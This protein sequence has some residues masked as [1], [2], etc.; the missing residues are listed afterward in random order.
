MT[1]KQIG[2]LTA[3]GSIADTDVFAKDTAGGVT[4]KE[5]FSVFKSTLKT[6][7]DSLT[8][9]F[10]NKRVTR[11]AVTVTQS[12]TPTINTDNADVAHITGLAQAITSMTTGLSG[13][14]VEGDTLRVDITDDGTARAISWGASF[15]ASG[16]VALPTTTVSGV[17][18]DVG[19]L[20]N[21]VSNKWRIV[22]TA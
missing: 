22:A 18:L 13:T 11:R 5:A 20:W 4:Y 21:T 3:Q 6:Y 1:T 19:F 12:A 8:T 10:T 17:R 15:E 2:G 7:F 16:N 9:T 14:P